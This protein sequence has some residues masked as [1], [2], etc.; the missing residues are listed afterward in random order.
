MSTRVFMYVHVCGFKEY[1]ISVQDQTIFLYSRVVSHPSV[2]LL[3]TLILCCIL[4]VLRLPAEVTSTAA[5]RTRRETRSVV[6]RVTLPAPGGTP[7]LVWAPSTLVCLET[8]SSLQPPPSMKP[9]C[10]GRHRRWL[11]P[12][13]VR[14]LW[15]TPPTWAHR[16]PALRL[17][18]ALHKR[19]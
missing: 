2:R 1:P 7:L 6:A 13:G 18:L 19:C 12:A 5:D 17:C 4:S 14:V 11:P 8:T 10:R 3:G 9:T 16:V 15:P